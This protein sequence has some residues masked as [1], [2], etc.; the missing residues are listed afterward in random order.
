GGRTHEVATKKSNAL[1][2]YDMTGN[3]SE[4]GWDTKDN[5]SSYDRVY[6]GG[7]W[8]TSASSCSL[9]FLATSAQ[10]HDNSRGVRLVRSVCES[11]GF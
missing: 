1:G 9:G 10:Y 6:F 5:K 7:H 3:V 8:N 4:W 11:D 2:L